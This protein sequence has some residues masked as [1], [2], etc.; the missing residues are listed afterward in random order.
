MDRLIFTAFSGLNASMVRQRVIASNMANAQTIGFRADTLQFTP[1][2]VKDGESLEVRALSDAEVRGADMHEGTLTQTGKP[3]DVA[4]V[5]KALLAV[6]AADGSESYTRRGDLAVSP[7]GVLVNG[8]GAPVIG[9]NG[10][11][12]IPPGGEVSIAEDGAVLVRDPAVPDAPPNKVDRL[13][14][15]SP[16]GTRIEKGLDGLLRVYG[17]G[18]LP[19]DLEA[20]LVPGTLEQSNVRPSDVL[21]QMVEAQR[22]FDIRTKLISTAKELDEGG[23]ALMRLS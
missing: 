22:L 2:T 15:A 6:Q 10:P 5:G 14:L 21:V 9:E 8:D 1:M 11:I 4:L 13:K 17:G 19:G 3:L 20:R 23:A 12:S 18:A 7:S 16:A